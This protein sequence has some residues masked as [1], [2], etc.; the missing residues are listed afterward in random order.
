MWKHTLC[1][2]RIN[3]AKCSNY[4]TQLRSFVRYVYT[5]K[6]KHFLRMSDDSVLGAPQILRNFCVLVT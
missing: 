2:H 3:Q 6:V 5:S 1:K 4:T